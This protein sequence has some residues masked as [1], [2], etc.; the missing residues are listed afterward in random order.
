M[1]SIRLLGQPRIEP[2]GQPLTIRRRK[3]R[4]LVYYL[5]AQAHPRTRD[6]LLGIF[7]PGLDRAAAQSQARRSIRSTPR[8]SI[9]SWGVLPSGIHT[10][11]YPP[12]TIW[13]CQNLE[14]RRRY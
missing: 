11:P 4:A 13:T 9:S 12:L 3:S 5:A 14:I 8:T 7:W 10:G 1:C 2:D 6:H